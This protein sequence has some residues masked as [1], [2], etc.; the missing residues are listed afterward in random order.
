MAHAIWSGAIN[1]GLV[2]IPVKLMTAV[3]EHGDLRFHFLHDKDQ[4]RIKNERV[5]S[6]CGKKVAWDD[7]VR[8][9]EYSKGEYVVIED[10]DFKKAA[11]EATQSVDIVE[12][13][14]DAEIDPM[15]F[16]RAYY[17][18]PEKKGKHAYALLRDALRKANKVGVARVVLRSR[19]Y[20][21]AVRPMKDAIVL[22]MLH[23]HDEIVDLGTLDLPPAKEEVPAPEMKAAQMLIDAMT[24]SFDPAEF[25]DRYREQ[26]KQL[27]EAKVEGKPAP[28]A[29]K[30]RAPTNV[31][32]LMDVLQKSLAEAGKREHAAETNGH[33]HAHKGPAKAKP[34]HG[35]A[36]KHA[37]RSAA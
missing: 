15:L 35:H 24:K 19:E 30:P 22:D 33:G 4:G 18:E 10:E 7:V 1:F 31:L 8:G 12:F 37:K 6:E 16:D 27:I 25:H 2:S 14:D 13:V 26:L 9:Y 29:A 28:K 3:R 11:P 36:K 5:C 17:L 21:A 23:W 20:L 32:N 34:R